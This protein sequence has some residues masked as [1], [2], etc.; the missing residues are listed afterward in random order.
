MW[1]KAHCWPLIQPIGRQCHAQ[2]AH[3]FKWCRVDPR[4]QAGFG[5]VPSS[6]SRDPWP[7][8]SRPGPPPEERLAAL[9]PEL[10]VAADAAELELD[11]EQLSK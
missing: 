11:Q 9:A 8:P 4:D 6:S 1:Q 7:P 2:G 10:G 3:S 5:A